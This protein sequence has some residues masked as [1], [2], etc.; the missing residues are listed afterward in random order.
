[1][2]Y[3]LYNLEKLKQPHVAILCLDCGWMRASWSRHDYRKCPCPN[4]AMI[5][6]GFD[7]IR[8]GAMKMART[9]MLHLAPEGFKVAPI[10]IRKAK[11]K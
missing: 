4:G 2:K 5:D 9:Q 10:K 6:G 3:L 7:Y 1:M 8:C 11:K